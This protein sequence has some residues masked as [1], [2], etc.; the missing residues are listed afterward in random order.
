MLCAFNFLFALQFAEKRTESGNFGR[1]DRGFYTTDQHEKSMYDQRHF[2]KKKT[3][4]YGDRNM[5]KDFF[6]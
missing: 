1:A 4:N 3:T 5:I 6:A 2:L